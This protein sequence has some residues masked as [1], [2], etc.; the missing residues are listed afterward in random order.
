MA[1]RRSGR[2]AVGQTCGCTSTLCFQTF[3]LVLKGAVL[4][5]KLETKSAHPKVEKQTSTST[6]RGE[7]WTGGRTDQR[8]DVWTDKQIGGWTNN[9]NNGRAPPTHGWTDE[10]ADRQADKRAHWTK[11][12]NQTLRAIDLQW[13]APRPDAHTPEGF[14]L[15][16]ERVSRRVSG[17]FRGFPDDVR[18][19]DKIAAAN[20]P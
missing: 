9:V 2:K 1:G 3:R 16:F 13:Q 17:G 7:G 18:R 20:T 19:Q 4:D 6:P 8:T 12:W 10:R 14:P 11:S 5:K 15:R